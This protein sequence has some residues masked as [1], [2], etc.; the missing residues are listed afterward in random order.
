MYLSYLCFTDGLNYV[1]L[2]QLVFFP[3]LILNFGRTESTMWKI[4]SDLLVR[5]CLPF[6]F[7]GNF[8]YKD[9]ALFQIFI[10]SSSTFSPTILPSK[11]AYCSHGS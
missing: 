11:L 5:R 10:R 4:R 1:N 2:S 7:E 3:K 9:S 8:F 6:V